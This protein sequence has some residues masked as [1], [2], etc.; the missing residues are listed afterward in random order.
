M[1]LQ[2]LCDYY[3]RKAKDLPSFGFEEK[4]IP[5][6]IVLDV[7]G[8]FIQLED[9]HTIDGGETQVRSF[10]VPKAIGRSSNIVAYCLWDHFGYVVAQPKLA[11]PDAVPVQKDIDYA[12]KQHDSFKQKVSRI[13]KDLPEDRGVRAVDRFLQSPDEI[14]KLKCSEKWKECLKIKGCNLTFRLLNEKHL[15]CASRAVISWVRRQPLQNVRKGFCMITGE[16]QADIVRLHDEISGVNQ[17]PAPLVAINE[18]AYTSHR[19]KKDFREKKYFNFSVSAQSA[20]EYATALNHLLSKRSENKFRVVG[21]TYVCWS[22]KQAKLENMLSRFLSDQSDDPNQ[23][24][25]AVTGLF[26]SIRNGAYQGSDGQQKFFL[27]GL[28]PNRSRIVVRYWKVGTVADFSEHIAQWFED[29]NLIGRDHFD[30]PVFGKLLDSTAPEE[31]KP[32]SRNKRMQNLSADLLRSILN[33][34]RLPEQLLQAAIRRIKINRVKKANRKPE[35][36]EAIKKLRL[37]QTCIVKAYLNRKYRFSNSTSK[38]VSMSLDKNE[39]RIGYCLG[40]LFAILEKIQ[41]DAHPGINSTIRDRYYSSASSTPKSVLGTLMR[42]STH[43]IKK[44]EDPAW[45]INAEKRIGE[46]ME[47]IPDFP[48]H[49][50][51]EN[52]GL[53]AIGYYHQKQDLYTKKSNQ[54][55]EKNNE[56]E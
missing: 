21:T 33:G 45:R 34:T 9:N 29:L 35:Q 39:A 15:V 49:L 6:T 19:E 47:L 46:V 23:M 31:E 40:R 41:S 44:L 50:N 10:R 54:A 27:L 5:F 13:A 24:T 2:A 32:D 38:E 17:S 25:Q 56:S 37:Y 3:D 1:I 30:Y 53:F 22:E 8:H 52:Q 18:R 14:E 20:F 28:S 16:Q 36:I 12:R 4:K 51:L 11:K 26:R 48:S 43:H 42:L 7:Y 55:E